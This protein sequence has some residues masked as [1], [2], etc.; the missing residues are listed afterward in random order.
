MHFFS[1][2]V[3]DLERK[4]STHWLKHCSEMRLYSLCVCAV[5]VGRLGLAGEGGARRRR[6]RRRE[7]EERKRRVR[8]RA[9]GEQ[10]PWRARFPKVERRRVAAAGWRRPEG[11]A[12]ETEKAA[13][14]GQ[15][16]RACESEAGQANASSR[17]EDRETKAQ[18]RST[19]RERAPTESRQ[20]AGS[21]T[22]E[23]RT[24][25]RQKRQTAR[26]TRCDS[27][28]QEEAEGTPGA[29]RP[30]RYPPVRHV[31]DRRICICVFSRRP[32]VVVGGGLG[33]GCRAEVVKEMGRQIGQMMVVVVGSTQR[34]LGE[35]GG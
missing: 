9:D 6:R 8:G 31:G 10:E 26:V 16:S 29:A 35:T 15:V 21:E 18:R 24:P 1:G 25:E 32:G 20:R 19:S 13:R 3:R 5:G 34:H 23:S 17:V 12:R 2:L 30:M 27:R 4:E 22:T 28:D 11:A 7:R 33:F 14:E